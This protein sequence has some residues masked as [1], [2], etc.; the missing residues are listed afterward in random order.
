[1][2]ERVTKKSIEAGIANAVG[3]YQREQHGRGAVDVRAHLLSD[4]VVIRSGG[5]FT[6][7]EAHLAATEDGRRLIKSARQELRSINRPEM[8]AIVAAIVESAI[9]RSYYD[10]DVET[11][12]QVDVLIL[13]EDVEQRLLRDE[14]ERL[15]RL[16]PPV[17]SVGRRG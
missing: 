1:M 8:E 12:E 11:A 14:V 10:L 2:S 15:T 7:T 17:E 4:M 3:R 5:I 13:G 9:L 6:P 16:A